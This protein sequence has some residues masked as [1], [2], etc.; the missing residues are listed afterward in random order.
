MPPT[1]KRDVPYVVPISPHDV[2]I[3]EALGVP[4]INPSPAFH[5]TGAKYQEVCSRKG[6]FHTF[7]GLRSKYR[8]SA[9]DEGSYLHHAM[10][11]LLDGNP[12]RSAQRV[13]NELC[14]KVLDEL[15]ATAGDEGRH[16]EDSEVFDIR[17]A[18]A[19]GYSCAHMV[20]LKLV[21]LIDSGKLR[22]VGAEVPLDVELDVSGVYCRVRCTLDAV[23]E[24]GE[25]ELITD[26]KSVGT[27]MGEAT[28]GYRDSLQSYLYTIARRAH[29]ESVGRDWPVRDFTYVNVMKPGIRRKGLHTSSPQ[30]LADYVA[31]CEEWWAGRGRHIGR[32]STAAKTPPVQLVTLPVPDLI[33]WDMIS[34]MDQYATWLKDFSSEQQLFSLY[35]FPR[36]E[37]ACKVGAMKCPYWRLCKEPPTSW[38]QV[39]ADHYTQ[40]PDPLDSDSRRTTNGHK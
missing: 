13:V 40:E 33:P 39:V 34:R 29:N 11:A 2:D 17:K 7:F 3:R 18:S 35:D 10:K 14:D 36:V 21:P 31:E 16:V 32:A 26:W 12:S 23:W 24:T 37:G 5:S 28:E 38:A 4:V 22:L 27:H 1:K 6:L 19:L 20:W 30:S 15:H 8:K 9:F 25:G